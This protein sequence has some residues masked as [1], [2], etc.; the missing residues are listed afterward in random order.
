MPYNM[1]SWYLFFAVVFLLAG[2]YAFV[3]RKTV[4]ILI[5]SG[6]MFFQ[7]YHEGIRLKR[8]Q[9]DKDATAEPGERQP[10]QL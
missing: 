2:I 8:T 7:Y 6:A 9:N 10:Q 1:K 4:L 5:F 3:E